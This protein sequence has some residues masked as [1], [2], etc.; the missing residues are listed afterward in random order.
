MMLD[1]FFEY[2]NIS[3]SIYQGRSQIKDVAKEGRWVIASLS[4]ANK[5]I[6][7]FIEILNWGRNER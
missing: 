6:N 5:Y 3:C 2:C 4:I 7:I 1:I